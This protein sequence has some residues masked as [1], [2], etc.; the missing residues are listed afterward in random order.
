MLDL[1]EGLPDDS[2]TVA[3]MRGGRQWRG[4]TR[5]VA[6]TADVF[7]AVN[8]TT[9]AAG[10][11]KRHPPKIPPYPRPKPAGKAGKKTRR[12]QSIAD[13]RRAFGIPEL[14]PHIPPP[15]PKKK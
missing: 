1:V 11:W 8:G 9:R 2:A 10:R 12:G 4:W 13:V 5:Q 15:Q 7:D 14:P 6:V 3:A